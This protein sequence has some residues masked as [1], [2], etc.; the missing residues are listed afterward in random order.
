MERK[1]KKNNKDSYR[2]NKRISDNNYHEIMWT[3]GDCSAS[4]CTRSSLYVI[5]DVSNIKSSTKNLKEIQMV[6]RSK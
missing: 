4:C 2:Q 1:M 6:L 3:K 5:I